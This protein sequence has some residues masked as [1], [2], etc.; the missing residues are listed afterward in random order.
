MQKCVRHV[1]HSS[2]VTERCLVLPQPTRLFASRTA[3]DMGL[4]QPL[5]KDGGKPKTIEELAAPTGASPLLVN[6][7][8]RKLSM[9]Q[10]I[11][12][13]SPAIDEPNALIHVLTIP[14]Y[15]EG[16]RLW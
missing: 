5:V 1:P 15:S 4:F 16:I 10:M 12:Q 7:I 8:A 11:K 13:I 2:H 14:K 6:R 3:L 9:S